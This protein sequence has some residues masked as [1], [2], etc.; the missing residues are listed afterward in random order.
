MNYV[1]SFLAGGLSVIGVMTVLWLAFYAAGYGWTL[2]IER[3]KRKARKEK[4]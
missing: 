1:Y 4:E 2:G 3:A